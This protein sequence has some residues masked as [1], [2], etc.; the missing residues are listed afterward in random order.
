MSH[1]LD[2]FVVAL[3][4]KIPTYLATVVAGHF[5]DVCGPPPDASMC[6]A[7]DGPK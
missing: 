3:L 4:R 2:V 6:A 7:R 1:D 5:R